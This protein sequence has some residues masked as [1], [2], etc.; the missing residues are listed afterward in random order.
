MHSEVFSP[1]CGEKLHMEHTLQ[2]M[3]LTEYIYA[4]LEKIAARSLTF[5]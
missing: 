2:A 4:T 1:F 5:S 3:E